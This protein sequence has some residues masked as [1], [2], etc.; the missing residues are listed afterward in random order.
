MD[1]IGRQSCFRD[2]Q[3]IGR[4]FKFSGFQDPVSG[5]LATGCAFNAASFASI[6][7]RIMP[8]KIAIIWVIAVVLIMGQ[9]G[10][11]K[12]RPGFHMLPRSRSDWAAILLNPLEVVAVTGFFVQFL[13]IHDATHVAIFWMLIAIIG[14]VPLSVV[15]LFL[16]RQRARIAI[17]FWVIPLLVLGL[18]LLNR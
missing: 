14:L 13:R 6:R 16:D 8:I 1:S 18:I 5:L 12:K 11:D 15:C 4:Y 3:V 2:V 17:A 7:D 9:P 10:R